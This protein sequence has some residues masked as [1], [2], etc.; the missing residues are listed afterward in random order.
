MNNNSILRSIRYIFKISDSQMIHIFSLGGT[1]VTREDVCNWLKNDHDPSF[2]ECSHLQMAAY[3]SGFI[4][5]KRGAQDGQTRQLEKN[6]N[7]N[8]I[9]RKLKIAL[10]LH[11]QDILTILDSA[12]VKIS[13][14]ELSA[15]FR[16]KDHKHYRTCKDQILRRFLQGLQLK[17]HPSEDL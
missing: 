17:H 3:L 9:F 15:F 16:K 7:N 2:C 13:K 8:L 12:G 4:I 10:H 11:D 14:H 5:Y 6:L 1:K